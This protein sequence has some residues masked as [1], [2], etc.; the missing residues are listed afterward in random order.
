LGIF[1]I[2][3]VQ[4]FDISLQPSPSL[5]RQFDGIHFDPEQ[6]GIVPPPRTGSQGPDG[7]FRAGVST[8]LRDGAPLFKRPSYLAIEH[9]A[10]ANS[11]SSMTF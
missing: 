4:V 1:S 9:I 11:T 3:F 2:R 8:G 6:R 7:L 10:E 5:R